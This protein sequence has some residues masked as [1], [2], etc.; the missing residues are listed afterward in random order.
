M[1]KVKIDF[2][3]FF[4]RGVK[5]ID[6]EFMIALITGYQ[7][8]GKTFYSI[9]KME[10]MK[11]IRTIYTNVGTYRSRKHEV[12]YFT[13]ISELYDNHEKD[14]IFLIEELVNILE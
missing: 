4:Q 10:D 1:L 9:K 12:H 3:S 2:K 11:G 14:A 8:S 13:N 7:G 6:N 5:N